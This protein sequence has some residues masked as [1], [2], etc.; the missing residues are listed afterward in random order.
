M[1]RRMSGG[2]QIGLSCLEYCPWGRCEGFWRGVAELTYQ[3]IGNW[4]SRVSEGY[5]DLLLYDYS[6]HFSFS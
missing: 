1:R 3:S 5:L 4:W 6:I 2:L